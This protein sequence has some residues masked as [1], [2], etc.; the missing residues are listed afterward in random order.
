MKIVLDNF[1]SMSGGHIPGNVNPHRFISGFVPHYLNLANEASD[2]NFKQKVNPAYPLVLSAAVPQLHAVKT[3]AYPTVMIMNEGDALGKVIYS[4]D[5]WNFYID[6]ASETDLGIPSGT[7]TSNVGIDA[8]VF[9]GKI[10]TSHPA[11]VTTLFHGAINATPSWTATTGNA[12]STGTRHI[13]RNFQDRCLVSDSS[14]GA[15][16]RNDVVDIVKPDFSIISGITLGDTFNILD[17]QN[18]QDRYALLFTSKTNSP[19]LI[20]STTVFMWNGQPGDTYDQKFVLKGIY[21]CSVEKDGNVFVFTQVGTTLVCFIFDDGGFQEIARV[22]NIVVSENL[23]IPKTR[24]SVEGDFFVILATS[25]DNTTNTAPF[26]WNPFNGDSFFIVKAIASVPY[27]SILIAQDPTSSV[28]AYDRYVAFRNSNGDGQIRKIGM[29]SS[30]K[31]DL[32]ADYK[33]NFIPA[34]IVKKIHDDMGRMQINHIDVEYS[35][36][37]PSV[38]DIIALTLT[39]K[40]EHVSETY[41]T[42]SASIKNTTANS[43]NARVGD[44]R[45]YI[46]VGARCTE[47][48]IDLAG[49]IATDSWNLIIRRIVLDV[50]PI[51]LT[52]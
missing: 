7:P 50:D 22:R 39:T 25:S 28:F 16:T 1:K 2:A 12:V 15:F 34:P 37:P 47:F 4:T 51:A 10:L 19:R 35:V 32:G 41:T 5:L 21:K 20:S 49:T 6:D 38:D 44:K 30:T 27:R 36:K 52:T 13:L 26:Y 11:T 45:A 31:A 46:K 29:E 23:H 8:V 24:I 43:T 33:S 42:L 17:I 14:S 3:G 18:F 48:A 40:D 9:N